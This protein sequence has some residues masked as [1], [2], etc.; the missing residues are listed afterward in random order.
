M[1]NPPLT[2]KWLFCHIYMFISTTP[3]SP[4]FAFFLKCLL[5]CDDPVIDFSNFGLFRPVNESLTLGLSLERGNELRIS[6][7]VKSAYGKR[8][9]VKKN[10]PPKNVHDFGDVLKARKIQK[11]VPKTCVSPRISKCTIWQ[12]VSNDL[13]TFSNWWLDS[14]FVSRRLPNP[15]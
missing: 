5:F 4:S 8:P 9:L 12:L 3:C 14:P 11:Q 13:S 7:D 15:Q 1:S 2:W 6:F 10:D